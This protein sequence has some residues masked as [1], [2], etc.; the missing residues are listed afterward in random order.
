MK[1]IKTFVAVAAI[2]MMS[3]GAFAQSISATSSTLDGA[4]AQIAAKA[5]E[6]GASYTITSALV[7]NNVHMTA[8]LDK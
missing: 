7:N 1:T 2:S 5:A 4:E 3:F 8:H 6:Q